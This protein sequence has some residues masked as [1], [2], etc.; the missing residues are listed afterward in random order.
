[1]P[2]P[3]T[4]SKPS[5]RG[6]F[7]FARALGGVALVAVLL[8]MGLVPKMNQQKQLAAES[9]AEAD[10]TPEV[11]VVSPHEAPADALV[12]P[13]SVQAIANTAVQAR[14]SGYIKTLMVDIG[15]RVKAGQVLAEIESPDAD[16]QVAQ[17]TADS[18]KSQATVGQSMAAVVKSRAGVAQTKAELSRQ[19]AAVKQAQAAYVGAQARLAQAVAARDQAEAKAAQSRQ[20]VETQKANLAQ[21]QAQAELAATT[22]KR[23]EGLLKEGFVARQDYDQAVAAYKTTSASVQAAESNIQAAQSDAKA[24]EQSVR[25]SEALI[26]AAKSDAEAAK[27]NVAAAQAT[28]ESAASNVA[29]AQADVAANEQNVSA[30]RAAVQ[31]SIANTRRYEVLRSFQRIVAPFDGVITSRNVDVGSLV[32]PGTLT[33]QSSS[34]TTPTVGLFGIARVDKLKIL[35]DVPQTDFRSIRAG[36]AATITIREFPGQTFKG[37]VADSAG[38]LDASS[39]T[40]LTEIDIP[41]PDNRLLPGMFAQVSLAGAS[42]NTVLRV[43]AN[44]VVFGAGGARVAVVDGSGTV[45][46]RPVKVGRDFGTELEVTEGVSASDR[47]V[48]NPSDDLRDGQKVKVTKGDE[49]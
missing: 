43:P 22:V 12:L 23:Y 27:A 30:N 48:S 11:E 49:S 17:A 7:P 14:T 28:A 19:R 39:R 35:V 2:T 47:L 36:D 29:A 33:A 4:P 25:A 3:P 5:P 8:A 9:H 32:S 42:K 1:M 37:V 13:G 34:T 20:A 10:A 15:S 6:G 21:A 46:F 40:L 41:N 24:A 31:S 26:R 18:A 45:H 16:E 38:A 44:A